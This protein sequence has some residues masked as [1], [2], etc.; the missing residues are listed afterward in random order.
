MMRRCWQIL[1]GGALLLGCRAA[2]PVDDAAFREMSSSGG[3]VSSSGGEGSSGG[4]ETACGADDETT[5]A[6]ADL[7][8][9]CGSSGPALPPCEPPGPTP[10]PP[11]TVTCERNLCTHE[12]TFVVD[13]SGC[14]PID[15]CDFPPEVC[16]GVAPGQVETF[17]GECR[18]QCAPQLGTDFP[19]T[20][21]PNPFGC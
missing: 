3:E 15:G 19:G 9:D 21:L 2:G 12:I 10:G 18:P 14:G 8:H 7:P 16:D 20:A 6:P 17:T 1:G 5:A 11:C 4:D 13:K